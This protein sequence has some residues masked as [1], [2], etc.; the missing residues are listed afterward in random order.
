MTASPNLMA[1]CYCLFCPTQ[2]VTVPPE[3]SDVPPNNLHVIPLEWLKKLSMVP[4][5]S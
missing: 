5:M 4:G 2:S 1:Q 3:S